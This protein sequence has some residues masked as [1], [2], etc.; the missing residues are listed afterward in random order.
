M[1]ATGKTSSTVVA[2]STLALAASLVLLLAVSTEAACPSK[3][4]PTPSAPMVTGGSGS[5]SGGGKCP[6]DALKLGVCADVLGL[7]DGLTNLMAGSWSTASSGKKPCCELV[8]GL[9]DLDAAVCLCT[10]IKANVLGVVDVG[11]PLQLGLLVNHCGRK[12]PAGF[13]C[14][15]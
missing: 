13:Q 1:A 10:A 5:G 12:L 6:V 7:G 3:S 9:A 14:P 4:K 11:L 8:D 15:N 2:M